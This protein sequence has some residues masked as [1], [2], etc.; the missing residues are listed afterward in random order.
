MKGLYLPASELR[1]EVAIKQVTNV[2]SKPRDSFL[3]VSPCLL[4]DAIFFSSHH[5]NLQ[6]QEAAKVY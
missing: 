4:C 1:A 6:Q 5:R 2:L 3:V